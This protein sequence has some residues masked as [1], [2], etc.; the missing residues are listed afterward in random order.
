MSF[1]WTALPRSVNRALARAA[2]LRPTYAEEDLAEAY[3][4]PPDDR[5]VQDLWSVL[6]DRW[7]ASR[8]DERRTVIDALRSANLGDTS[9][10]IYSKVGQMDY[11]RSCRNSQGLR[12]IV[13]ESL[14]AAGEFDGSVTLVLPV[15]KDKDKDD[16]RLSVA[17]A[18]ASLDVEKAKVL[19]YYL[20]RGLVEV[21][22]PAVDEMPEPADFEMQYLSAVYGAIVDSSTTHETVDAPDAIYRE[23]LITGA[24]QLD[25]VDEVDRFF[26]AVRGIARRCATDIPSDSYTALMSGMTGVLGLLSTSVSEFHE[27]VWNQIRSD[28][29]WLGGLL[30]SDDNDDSTM[31]VA[32]SSPSGGATPPDNEQQPDPRTDFV[33][34]MEQILGEPPRIEDDGRIPVRE[35]SALLFAEVLETEGEPP[36][37]RIRSLLVEE[38]PQSEE[39]L[40]ALNSIN[41]KLKYCKAVLVDNRVFLDST[42]PTTGITPAQVWASLSEAMD[43]ADYYDT[44]IAEKFG[45]RTWFSDPGEYFDA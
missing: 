44:I 15:D 8:P 20:F 7:L 9:I 10:S 5:V 42:F 43:N 1:S 34:A 3:G 39:L 23:R 14:I 6:R 22:G 11:L 18:L 2:G 29:E 12:S 41:T 17:N 27:S 45:G 33:A 37:I 38:V 21:I 24:R 31:E 28:I 13:L 19:E 30:G 36:A 32:G 35:G 40:I 16:P 4:E 25:T 26:G